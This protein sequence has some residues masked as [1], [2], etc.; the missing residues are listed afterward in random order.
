MTLSKMDQ[1]SLS[2][3]KRGRN[4]PLSVFLLRKWELSYFNAEIYPLLTLMDSQ[5][6]SSKFGTVVK[7]SR[8]PLSYMTTWIH[9]SIKHLNLTLK[10]H[11][12]LT[13]HHWSLIFMTRITLGRTLSVGHWYILRI[14]LSQLMMKFLDLNGI[15]ANLNLMLLI[16]V[17]Y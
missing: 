13:F 8:K 14:V 1:L 5:I 4:H 7:M 6:L 9:C 16:A 3:L 15:L 11:H 2:I 12:L 10:H 17:R